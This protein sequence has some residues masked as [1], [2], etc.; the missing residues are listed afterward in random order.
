MKNTA[1]ILYFVS[2][3]SPKTGTACGPLKILPRIEASTNLDCVDY[4]RR[5][6]LAGW[7]IGVEASNRDCRWLYLGVKRVRLVGLYDRRRVGRVGLNKI[8]GFLR[9]RSRWAAS[10]RFRRVRGR[11]YL[12]AIGGVGNASPW[13][14][15][16]WQESWNATRMR[17]VSCGARRQFSENFGVLLCTSRRRPWLDQQAV[18]S[19]WR[20]WPYSFCPI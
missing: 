10:A 2:V 20:R 19:S 16:R 1:G 5:V 4:R 9:S 13:A 11:E 17:E 12:R 15:C 3:T 6:A 7:R 14:C 18:G 8:V